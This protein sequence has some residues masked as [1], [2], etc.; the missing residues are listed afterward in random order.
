MWMVTPCVPRGVTAPYVRHSM[1]NTPEQAPTVPKYT[2]EWGA[3]QGVQNGLTGTHRVPLAN[4][5]RFTSTEIWASKR[6]T[7]F[8]LCSKL[9]SPTSLHTF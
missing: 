7:V 9:L 4:Y 6:T 2:Q 3:F 5:P 1:S 8:H